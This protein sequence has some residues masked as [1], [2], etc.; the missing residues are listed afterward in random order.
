MVNQCNF[1]FI[2]KIFSLTIQKKEAGIEFTTSDQYVTIPS[3]PI[4]EF[5]QY[6][7]G[8][9]SISF[10]LKY[11][12]FNEGYIF[13]YYSA[14][15]NSDI[16]TV[17]IDNY[18][19][20]NIFAGN[21]LS[22]VATVASTQWN[23]IT[24]NFALSGSNNNYVSVYKNSEIILSSILTYKSFPYDPSGN[25]ARIGG[26]PSFKGSLSNF[27]IFTYGSSV[28]INSSNFL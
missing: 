25:A 23:I 11:L 16:I 12:P 8:S 6:K 15:S 4:P 1:F 24:I 26:P 18:G 7:T 10:W 20:L 13:R 5:N 19:V 2:K 17:S 14:P 3:F 28:I 21:T 22:S 9:F 27:R